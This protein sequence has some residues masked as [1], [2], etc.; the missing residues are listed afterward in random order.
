MVF[1]SA[2]KLAVP[3][4]PPRGDHVHRPGLF[5]RGAVYSSKM[6]AR[7]RWTHPNRRAGNSVRVASEAPKA[8]LIEPFDRL[9]RGRTA[10]EWIL[11]R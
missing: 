10:R 8:V 6:A 5:A 1:F 3:R 2:V 4:A 11:R 9:L 7:W